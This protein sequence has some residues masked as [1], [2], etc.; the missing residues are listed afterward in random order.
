MILYLDR[1]S[2][3]LVAR[4]AQGG[5]LVLREGI[6]GGQVRE[7][8]T[9]SP[10]KALVLR[11]ASCPEDTT[12]PSM[13]KSWKIRPGSLVRSLAEMSSRATWWEGGREET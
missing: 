2:D 13:A 6:R 8:V 11:L 5:Q 10:W 7:E 4:E 12:R 9:S 3:Q 1:D